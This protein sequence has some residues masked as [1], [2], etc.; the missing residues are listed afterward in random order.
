[1]LSIPE[2]NG[3]KTTWRLRGVTAD[4]QEQTLS[5]HEGVLL[6]ES[7]G[8]GRWHFANG[9]D[10][11]LQNDSDGWHFSFENCP[12]DLEI[13]D[14][15][16]PVW[17][18]AAPDL[19]LLLPESMG[20]LTGEI[21][22]WPEKIEFFR[23]FYPFQ[24]ITCFG[25]KENLLAMFPDE[26][27][28]CK[29]VKVRKQDGK[30]E[31]AVIFHVPQQEPPVDRYTVPFPVVLEK[32]TGGW[33]E[34]AERYRKWARSTKTFQRAKA[35]VNPL[36]KTAMWFWNRGGSKEVAEP[37]IR[38][39]EQSGLP[40]ALDW[41]WWHHN[42]YDTDYPFY[43]P[44]RE[45][46]EKFRDAIANL[47]AKG[48]FTQVYMNG[49]TW[50]MDN[51]SWES[52]GRQSAIVKEDG[53]IM[54]IAFN[55]YNH[56]RLAYLCG[57]SEPLQKEII[58]Q[59]VKLQEAGLDGLYL[60]QIGCVS[61]YIP[62]WNSQHH[63][64]KGGGDYHHRGYAEYLEE[65][66]KHCP[67]LSLSTEDCCEEYLDQ[68]DSMIV[69][70]NSSERM[71]PRWTEDFQG[72]FVPVFQAVY[73]G[74]SALFGTYAVPDGIP[75]WDDRWPSGDRWK[76]ADEKEWEKLYP[77]QFFLEM[78]RNVI[79]GMQPTVHCLRK[80]HWTDPRFQEIM[81]FL[82]DTAQ[83]YS[84]HLEWLFDG[85][86]MNPGQL[87][88]SQIPVRF[89]CRTIYTKKE[90][91]KTWERNLPAILHSVWRSPAG[92]TALILGN[93]TG[94]EQDFEFGAIRGSLEARSWKC[95]LLDED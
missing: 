34:A 16:F 83:F 5:S 24:M 11:E 77:E 32:F 57:E 35:K 61:N 59:A 47:K 28:Y 6:E 8:H 7:P 72:Q 76:E 13:R 17:E 44:P 3:V 26:R 33:F 4:G 63:H 95:I 66:R 86:M 92:K 54:N 94:E 82:L 21:Q 75:P 52:G 71:T 10:V 19:R 23:S 93:Y 74:T 78:T 60:D 90:N 89:M 36:R 30:S 25:E 48:V 39:A 65:V 69:L 14:I 85:E 40:V 15:H 84:R 20:F 79:C 56:H 88:V 43:W 81:K 29:N 45:G 37:V 87:T 42:P 91:F 18:L 51:P 31:A 27:F 49:M 12:P 38:F 2:L 73:H 80:R 1:M 22:Q 53:S 68:F 62:C 50:D 64:S 55:R 67:G 46:E 58:A 70:F 41:Y 9:L